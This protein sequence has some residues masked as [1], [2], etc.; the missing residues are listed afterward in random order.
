MTLSGSPGKPLFNNVI[1][2][3]LRI[4]VLLNSMAINQCAGVGI[5]TPRQ[6]STFE[7]GLE[8]MIRRVLTFVITV[9]SIVVCSAA[10]S[11]ATTL[12][13]QLAIPK[14]AQNTQVPFKVRGKQ[15]DAKSSDPRLKWA[16]CGGDAYKKGGTFL[17]G[18]EAAVV[19]QDSKTGALEMFVKTPA[20]FVWPTHWHAN[21]EHLLGI[22]GVTPIYFQDGTIQNIAPGEWQYIPNGLIHSAYC[23]DAGPCEFLLYTDKASDFNVVS[24]RAALRWTQFRRV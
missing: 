5:K 17:K 13:D 21:S 22:K 18:C 7:R 9:L 6:A 16:P 14:E 8:I 23:T 4:A 10:M 11:H 12:K 15:V 20:S 3:G 19:R 24:V 1:I 2:V